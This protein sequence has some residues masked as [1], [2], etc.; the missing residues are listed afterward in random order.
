M[1]RAAARA[2]GPAAGAVSLPAPARRPMMVRFCRPCDRRR[3]SPPF[4]KVVPPL[5]P[6]CNKQT[7]PLP[8]ARPPRPRAP[9]LQHAAAAGAGAPK[10]AQPAGARVP[11]ARSHLLERRPGGRRDAAPNPLFAPSP[12]HPFRH[13]S[14]HRA[15]DPPPRRVQGAQAPRPRPCAAVWQPSSLR[16]CTQPRGYGRSLAPGPASGP[17]PRVC[18]ANALAPVNAANPTEAPPDFHRLLQARVLGSRV[19]FTQGRRPR[20]ARLARVQCWVGWRARG[21]WTPAPDVPPNAARRRGGARSGQPASGGW[22]VGAPGLGVCGL[23][24]T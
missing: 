19:G 6:H 10:R 20:A 14:V 9:P 16:G 11:G 21:R 3:P 23:D 5:N 8:P 17:R 15:A 24:P 13:G 18:I 12:P 1:R 22:G 7:N 4:S 2:A